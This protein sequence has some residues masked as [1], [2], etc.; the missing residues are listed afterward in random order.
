MA[1]LRLENY[2]LSFLIFVA[3][4]IAGVGIISD[5]NTNYNVS[6]GNEGAFNT[7]ILRANAAYNSTYD[8]GL[9]AKTQVVDADIAS[10]TTENSMF[11][12]AFA[13]LK[14]FANMFGIVGGLINDIGNVIGIPTIFINVGIIAFMIILSMAIIYLVFR[15]KP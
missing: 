12:G 9:S 8:T 3:V 7:T 14:T 15:F 2:L 4:I 10:D 1:D 13:A 6:M 11:K 5:V